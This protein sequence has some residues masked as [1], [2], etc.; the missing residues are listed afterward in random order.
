MQIDKIARKYGRNVAQL[1]ASV[2]NGVN[3]QISKMR[4]E[5][6][7]IVKEMSQLV[8]AKTAN[9]KDAEKMLSVMYGVRTSFKTALDR[10][11]EMLSGI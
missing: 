1:D 11:K 8:R 7:S 4:N 2:G 3:G 10:A 5:I 6:S 9:P